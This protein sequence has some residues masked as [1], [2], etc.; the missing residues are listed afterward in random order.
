MK[1]TFFGHSN[2]SESKKYEPIMLELLERLVGDSRV[3]MLLGEYGAFDNFAY[4]C[5]KKFKE[6]H[7]GV[8]LAFVTPYMTLEY[9]KNHLEYQKT[10][11]DTIIYPEIED[12]PKRFAITYRNR[13]MAEC[14]DIVIAYVNR[15]GG[16]YDAVKYAEK[17]EKK[18]YNLAEIN[19]VR[20]ID[21]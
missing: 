19:M 14:A 16:A 13:Y 8:S 18:I 9:Q 11:F 12:K 17:K 5:S 3:E 7:G 20:N 21:L 1:I 2:F 4:K 10:R 6:T 15:R